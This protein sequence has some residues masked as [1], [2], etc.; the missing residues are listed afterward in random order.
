MEWSQ[1]GI[2]FYFGGVPKLV[3]LTVVQSLQIDEFHKY[4]LLFS[5]SS[6]QIETVII[7]SDWLNRSHNFS[8][9]DA[10]CSIEII[11]G[12]KAH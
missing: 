10:G 5:W 8:N 12:V 9:V 4:A 7:E 3:Q 1:L 6:A 11:D 2:R